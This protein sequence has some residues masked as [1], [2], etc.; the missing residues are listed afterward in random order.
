[1]QVAHPEV[2]LGV[3]H[4]SDFRRDTLGR[5][6]R[7]LD[8]VYTIT[9]ASRAE[10]EA[11]AARVRASHAR[12]RG[13]SPQAYSAFSPHAQMWVLATLIQ[14]SVEMYERFVAPLD[15]A[16]RGAYFRDMR[17]FGVWF[18]LD[19]GHGPQTWPAFCQYYQDMLNSPALA[20]LPISRELARH[21]ARPEKPFVLR[22][23]WPFSGTVACEFLP[24]PVREKLG[25]HRSGATAIM[26]AT[27]DAVLPALL[28]GLPD[29]LRFTA[30]YLQA[31]NERPAP[32]GAG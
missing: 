26:A 17:T 21:I 29:Q 4:H 31:V 10:V 32:A 14:T 15:E 11:I 30:R 7:T 5:L 24:S 16:S 12:V 18:G 13:E 27:M 3:A 23:L 28:P 25:L 1:M 6:H 22:T 19:R 9:F 8:A 2:A 20:S